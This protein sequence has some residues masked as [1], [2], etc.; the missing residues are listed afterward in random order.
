MFVALSRFT[1]RNGMAEEVRNAFS[2]RPHLVDEAHGFLGMQVMSPV[3]NPA[4]IWLVTR[5]TNEQS[6][7]TCHKSHSYHESHNGIP[8]GLKLGPKST[9]IRFFDARDGCVHDAK[10]HFGKS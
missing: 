2:A 5:W 7:R 8:K 6:Y 10:A 1:I 4:E 3:E 9:E